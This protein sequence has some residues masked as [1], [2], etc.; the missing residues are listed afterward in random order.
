MLRVGLNTMNQDVMPSVAQT[1]VMAK[2]GLL[3]VFHVT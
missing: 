2:V 1:D 3:I